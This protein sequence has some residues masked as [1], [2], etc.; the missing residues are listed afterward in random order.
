MKFW[1]TTLVICIA[2]TIVSAAIALTF[3][4]NPE[5]ALAGLLTVAVSFLLAE[6]FFGNRDG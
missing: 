1:L 4:R 3:D 2:F 6:R 5:N